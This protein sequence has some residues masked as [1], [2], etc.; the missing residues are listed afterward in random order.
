MFQT[1]IVASL[2]LFRLWR[3]ND[4]VHIFQSRQSKNAVDFI[5]IMLG[6]VHIDINLFVHIL[7]N[8][9][10]SEEKTFVEVGV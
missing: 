6:V 4:D 10:H 7:A 9:I 1:E 2:Q 8:G 5:E 3:G